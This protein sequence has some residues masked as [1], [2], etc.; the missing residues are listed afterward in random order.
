MKKAIIIILVLCFQALPSSAQTL[1]N[2]Q[3]TYRFQLESTCKDGQQGIALY[4]DYL[5]TTYNA[6]P[7]IE[8][9][10]L[11]K[12]NLHVATLKLERN[13]RF[14]GNN[15]Q[16][17]KAFYAKGDPFP[18]LYI[19]SEGEHV[20]RVFRITGS[21]SQYNIQLVQTIT[22]PSTDIIGDYTNIYLNLAS[23]EVVISGYSEKSFY[24]SATNQLKYTTYDLPGISESAVT[25]KDYKSQFKM[26]AITATQ[27]G[28]IRGGL[29]CQVFGFPP[30]GS[31]KVIKLKTGKIIQEVALS[32]LGIT[33]EP[34]GLAMNGK[35]WLLVT[36]SGKCYD[37]SLS[38]K[39]SST[40]R[41]SYTFI[42]CQTPI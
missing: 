12:N 39:K 29:L 11:A 14:H 27:G 23:K 22:F 32:A 38:K 36:A 3:A 15:M 8:I 19:S 9:Y 28:F 26:K 42:G 18:L 10:N 17:S 2:A 21:E 7:Q 13:P 1:L 31:L 6:V 4:R 40:R 30:T 34:E 37:I 20:C 33:E 5:F 25:L 24:A 41:R 16:F 35:K